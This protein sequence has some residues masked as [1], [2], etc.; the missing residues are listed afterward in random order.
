M[1]APIAARR[2]VALLACLGL[3]AGLAWWWLDGGPARQGYSV[4]APDACPPTSAS[5][6]FPVPARDRLD[7]FVLP[8]GPVPVAPLTA[9]VC[10][11]AA[12]GRLA[13]A[14]ALDPGRTASLAAAVAT[15][16]TGWPD[17]ALAA[18]RPP[19][20][21]DAQLDAAKPPGCSPDG[22]AVVL[23][24]AY[25]HGPPVVVRVREGPCADL[26]NGTIILRTP[27]VVADALAALPRLG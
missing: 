26:T 9:T 13:G 1:S 17:D 18:K 24:F 3:A 5:T 2:P 27:P 14:L 12:G 16:V 8:V 10:R 15:P 11:Y 22:S 21:T 23:T 25:P 6:I 4:A 19:A 20:L 7:R